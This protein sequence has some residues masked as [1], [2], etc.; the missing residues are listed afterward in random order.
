MLDR[1]MPILEKNSRRAFLS[2]RNVSRGESLGRILLVSFS[3][4]IK[5]AIKDALG[6]GRRGHHRW[7]GHWMKFVSIK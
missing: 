7:Q 1:T 5:S 2:V 6:N 4:A 3:S